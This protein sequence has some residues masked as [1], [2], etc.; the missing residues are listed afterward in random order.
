MKLVWDFSEKL[1]QKPISEKLKAHRT[2]RLPHLVSLLNKNRLKAIFVKRTQ[3]DSVVGF[4]AS[5]I[6]EK[7]ETRVIIDNAFP[8]PEVMRAQVAPKLLEF[9]A[10]TYPS[11][12]TLW[13]AIIKD[14]ESSAK[15]MVKQGFTQS[16][17]M[18]QFHKESKINWQGYERPMP[19]KQKS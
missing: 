2:K 4:I 16:D 13:G 17:F 19:P 5:H 10:N 6:C 18:D 7:D 3:D 11:K 15:L 1:I 14:S 8:G 9:I 12:K